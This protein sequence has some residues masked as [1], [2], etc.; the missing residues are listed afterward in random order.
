MRSACRGHIRDSGASASL[1]ARPRMDHD[2][3]LRRHPVRRL[4]PSCIWAIGAVTM[5]FRDA[6][7]RP[8]FAWWH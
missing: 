1:S 8:A 2:L 3:A 5:D 4:P 7:W 6:A